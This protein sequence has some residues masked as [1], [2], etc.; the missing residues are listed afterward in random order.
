MLYP[1]RFILV[2]SVSINYSYSNFSDNFCLLR[3][4]PFD[5][6]SYEICVLTAALHTRYILYRFMPAADLPFHKRA[7][8]S[9]LL[10]FKS[11]LYGI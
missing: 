6:A 5:F 4:L 9:N 8:E 2:E 3:V 11:A 1:G 10:T 7:L